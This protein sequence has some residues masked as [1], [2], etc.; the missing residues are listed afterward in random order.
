MRRFGD[1]D[2]DDVLRRRKG[3]GATRHEARWVAM[4]A[5]WVFSTLYWMGS[6]Q[7]RNPAVGAT[8]RG[9]SPRSGGDC[10]LA[11][12]HPQDNGH[13]DGDGGRSWRK[14][15]RGAEQAASAPGNAL[16]IYIFNGA[17]TEGRKV[18]VAKSQGKAR[19]A[20]SIGRRWC[21]N[22][23]WLH[24]FTASQA[25][26]MEVGR[27]KSGKVHREMQGGVS[28]GPGAIFA[29]APCLRPCLPS[30]SK[31]TTAS[32]PELLAMPAAAPHPCRVET[33]CLRQA[34]G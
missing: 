3:P 28:A 30:S 21:R 27:G 22:F 1:S 14:S 4:R 17:M 13:G 32:G 10:G 25:P 20:G 34:N 6:G 18:V 33:H 9:P 19:R 26:S 15:K 16:L 5:R 23:S 2:G 12:A 31:P 29:E 7:L 8:Q 24:S 11:L